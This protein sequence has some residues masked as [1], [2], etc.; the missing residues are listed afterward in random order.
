MRRECR[1]VRSKKQELGMVG[2]CKQGAG[3]RQSGGI[4]ATVYAQA[5]SRGNTHG[6]AE[7][8]NN[9]KKKDDRPSRQERS[10]DEF[11]RDDSSTEN[12]CKARQTAGKIRRT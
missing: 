3:L 11:A 6:R 2:N 12:I 7:A 4:H 5:A 10:M 1:G 8:D 9:K